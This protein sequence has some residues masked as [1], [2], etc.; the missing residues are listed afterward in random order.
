M[1]IYLNTT[2]RK[3]CSTGKISI[4]LIESIIHGGYIAGASRSGGKIGAVGKE[5]GAFKDPWTVTN[6]DRHQTNVARIK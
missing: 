6:F 5:R 3:G 4:D 2:I 1:T